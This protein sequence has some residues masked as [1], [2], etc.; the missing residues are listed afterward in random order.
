[1][2]A[3]AGRLR[4]IAAV[5]LV[6]ASRITGTVLVEYDPRGVGI[7]DI[8]MV[9][10]R[11]QISSSVVPSARPDGQSTSRNENTRRL[12]LVGA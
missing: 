8:L 4:E 10:E 12:V 7:T 1:E 9:V 11:V 5:R 3:F 2:S 6:R